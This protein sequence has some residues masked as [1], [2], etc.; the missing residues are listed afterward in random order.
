VQAEYTRVK[1]EL[2]AMQMMKKE[3]EELRRNH[4]KLQHENEEVHAFGADVEFQESK[5]MISPSR[6]TRVLLVQVR[7]IVGDMYVSVDED[8]AIRERSVR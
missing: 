4:E 8:R 1:R 7:K 2:E 3:Y 5:G 6:S